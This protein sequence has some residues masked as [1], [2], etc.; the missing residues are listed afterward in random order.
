MTGEQENDRLSDEDREVLARMEAEG[1]E[2]RKRPGWRSVPVTDPDKYSDPIG[3]GP[4]GKIRTYSSIEDV[5]PR[6][7]LIIEDDDQPGEDDE[8]GQAR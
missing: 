5:P 6:A 1:A 2:A 4:D 3:M 7:E 8:A